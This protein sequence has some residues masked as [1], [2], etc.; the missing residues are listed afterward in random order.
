MQSFNLA[1]ALAWEEREIQLLVKT[2]SFTLWS[3]NL[4][5]S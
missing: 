5:E 2:L 1:A 3:S 4:R